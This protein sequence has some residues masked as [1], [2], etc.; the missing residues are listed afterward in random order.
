MDR[1]VLNSANGED[2]EPT[3]ISSRGKKGGWTTF[4]FTIATVAGIALAFGGLTG[5]LIVYLIQEFNIRSIS[6]AKIFNV[7]N[8]C[9]TILP[10]A[11]AII[12]DSFTGCY[13]VIWISSL[14]S[15]LGLLIIVLTAAISKLRPPHCENGSNLCKYPSEVQLAVLYIGLALGSIGMAGTRFTIGSMGANQFDKPK[16]Q[17][18]FFNWY[19]FTMYMATGISSTLI[20]YIENSVSWTL[21]FGICV[22][23]NIFALAIFL[24]GSGFYHHLKPQGSPF[25]R[26]ARVIVASFRKR[27]MVLSLKS[28][29]YFQ[30]PDTADYKVT[31]FPSKFFKFLNRAAL[32]AEGE[33]EPDGSTRQPWKLCTVQDVEDFKRIIK[34]FPLWST[35]FFLSTPLVILGSLSVLQALAMDRHLGPHF[36]IPAGSVFL[37]TLMPTCFTVFLLDR[38]LFP[39]WEK[40]TGHPVRPL[41]RVGIGHLLDIVGLAVLALVEAKRLKIA[42]LHDLQGQDNAV[43]PMSVFWLVPPLAIAGIGE[44]FFFPGQIDFYYQEF[45]ASLKS[46]STAAVALY[47]GI[48]YYLGNAVIDLV[49]RTRGWLPDDLNKGRLDNVYW[50][51]CVLAGLN[52]CYYLVCSYFYK[53]QNVETVKVT[54]ES[55]V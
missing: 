32:R 46:T 48:A 41:Q 34:I 31:T 24:A 6:A 22:A 12:A 26:L 25:V 53:Y 3:S 37:F 19:I 51:V 54:D 7:V 55:T 20:V 2:P 43:V 42:R 15:S 29:D 23:A 38:F 21:G 11:A 17:G 50:L 9:T 45:P 14:I 1:T 44:A 52:F 18:I 33:T 30:G 4:P 13:S 27:K 28:E 36:Q 39:L 16:H 8:G 35:G 5:N 40:F 47:M 49:R 10:I